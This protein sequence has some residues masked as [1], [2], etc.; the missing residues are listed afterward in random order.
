MQQGDAHKFKHTTKF[1][2]FAW[3]H[4]CLCLHL[5]ELKAPRIPQSDFMCNNKVTTDSVIE[6]GPASALMSITCV[7]LHLIQMRS[8]SW[9]T[10][11]SALLTSP[12]S[13]RGSSLSFQVTLLFT[14]VAY[15]DVH[16][17]SVFHRSVFLVSVQ[18]SNCGPQHTTNTRVNYNCEVV[19]R[20]HNQSD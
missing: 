6:C 12:Q 2:P 17:S 20:E 5:R 11:R 8:C 7:F 18:P 4:S 15:G 16:P 13:S 10:L 1:A 19:A 14:S 3:R 9:T